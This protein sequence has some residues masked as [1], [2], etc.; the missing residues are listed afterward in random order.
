MKGLL[1]LSEDRG[2]GG[3]RGFDNYCKLNVCYTAA[4]NELVRLLPTLQNPVRD[5]STSWL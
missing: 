4:S 3:S 1:T 2:V 5:K